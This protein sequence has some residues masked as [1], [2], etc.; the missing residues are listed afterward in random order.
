MDTSKLPAVVAEIAVI[1]TTLLYL[2]FH[3]RWLALAAIAPAAA[4]VVFVSRLARG[5]RRAAVDSRTV[6]VG[7]VR[8]VGAGEH[9]IWIEVASVHGDTFIGRLVRDDASG[10]P[11][12]RPGLVVL[13][14]F[15]PADREALSLPDDVLAVRASGLSFA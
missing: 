7:T 5:S 11:T 1:A 15:D 10:E 2:A 13:V 3:Q 6:S 14:A 4:A 8:E 12:L 9:Q